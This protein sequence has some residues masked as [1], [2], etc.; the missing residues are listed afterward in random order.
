GQVIVLD[1][2]AAKV[3]SAPDNTS[4]EPAIAPPGLAEP[5]GAGTVIGTCEYMAPE[6]ARGLVE[7]LDARADVFGL[8][9]ILYAILTGRPPYLGQGNESAEQRADARRQA[10]EGDIVPPRR[11]V[12]AVSRPLEAI[13]LKALAF[14][15]E[16]R[17]ASAGALADDIAN[18]LACEPVSAWPEPWANRLGRWLRRHRTAA[19]ATAPG[20]LVP[21]TPM[22]APRASLTHP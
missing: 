9:A 3:V 18:W 16:D 2:G 8:G 4:D 6:Q 14:R 17:Y 21:L 20:L 15:P 12:S 13:C 10:Q 22:A 19:A 11:R 1:W 5:T 7:S